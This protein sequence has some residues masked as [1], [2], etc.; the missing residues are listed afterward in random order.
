MIISEKY[1]YNPLKRVTF[2][3][4]RHYETPNGVVPSVTTVLG[5]TGDKSGLLAWRK[6]LGE[7]EATRQTTEAA[8]IGTLVHKHLECYIRGEERPKGNN[9]IQLLARNMSDKVIV[10][11]L[12]P[13]SEVWGLEA[14][15]Y[16]PELYAGTAD[17]IGIY[18]GKPTILDFK[19]AKK[20]KKTEYVIDYFLQVAAY[21]LAHDL[22][23]GTNIKQ[24]VILMTNREGT[25]QKWILDSKQYQQYSNMWIA[26]LESYWQAFK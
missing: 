17:C 21:G 26:R 8:N 23:F 3:N 14:P 18:D 9:L 15:L 25:T 13:L 24:A 16:Y 7:K 10:E 1:Q 20:V 2:N 22:H 6:R 4:V 5:A 11:H 19:T 12:R